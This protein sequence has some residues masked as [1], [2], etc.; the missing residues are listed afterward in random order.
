LSQLEQ[1]M[2][3]I[4]KHYLDRLRAA[5]LL[6]SSEPFPPNHVSFPDGVIVGKPSSIPGNS[7]PGYDSL[8]VWGENNAP[9]DA[10]A[11]LFHFDGSEWIVTLQEFVPRPGPG[12][13]VDRW[14]TPAQAVADILDYYFGDPARM[15]E[16]RTAAYRPTGGCEKREGKWVT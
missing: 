9:L 5:G 16:C 6:V 2:A 12:D 14:H 15:D 10:P 3:E 4:P 8:N 13:F 1:N 7:I 11:I